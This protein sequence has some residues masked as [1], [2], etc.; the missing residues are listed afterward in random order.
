MDTQLIFCMY[1]TFFIHYETCAQKHVVFCLEKMKWLQHDHRKKLGKLFPVGTHECIQYSLPTTYSFK[2]L[3]GLRASTTVLHLGRSLAAF[4]ASAH[5]SW[6]A[7]SSYSMVRLHVVVG[8]PLLLLPCR[9]LVMLLFWR[10]RT[11]PFH[12]HL[13]FLMVSVMDSWLVCSHN[14]M[15]VI[16][17]GHLI[18]RICRGHL[19]T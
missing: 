14:S 9:I 4:F 13:R 15:L 10:L 7:F 16:F 19:L 12:F 8:L 17:S 3:E 2:P 1:V 18:C 5:V 6:Q 11:W